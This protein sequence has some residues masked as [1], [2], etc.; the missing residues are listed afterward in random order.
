[1]VYSI[2]RLNIPCSLSGRQP[3]LFIIE[4]SRNGRVAAFCACIAPVDLEL[5]AL[6]RCAAMRGLLRPEDALAPGRTHVDQNLHLAAQLEQALRDK[7]AAVRR[8]K[9]G[10]CFSR[11]RTL[12]SSRRARWRSV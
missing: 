11:D 6:R 4:D 2:A 5:V 12:G 8:G 7:L 10:A 9:T 1:M 3:V